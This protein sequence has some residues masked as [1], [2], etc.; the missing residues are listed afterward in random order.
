[1]AY[2]CTKFEHSSRF[3]GMKKDAKLTIGVLYGRYGQ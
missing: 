2:M 1:M 3:R